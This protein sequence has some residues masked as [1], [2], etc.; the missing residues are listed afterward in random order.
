M[1]KKEETEVSKTQRLDECRVL[2]TTGVKGGVGKTITAFLM[3][4]LHSRMLEHNVLLINCDARIGSIATAYRAAKDP[5]VQVVDVPLV[6]DRSYETILKAIERSRL[7]SDGTELDEAVMPYVIVDMPGQH[8]GSQH[9][10]FVDV[11]LDENEAALLWL[12]DADVSCI[13]AMEAAR[14]GGMKPPVPCIPG[15]DKESMYRWMVS[16]VR[17]DYGFTEENELWIPQIP[18]NIL[19][20]IKEDLLTPRSIIEKTAS[21]VT[22]LS[23]RGMQNY[24]V[25]FRDLVAGVRIKR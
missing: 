7:G 3:T 22:S 16:K 12:V 9:M 21:G 25:R 24:M 11:L 5:R 8:E 15:M 20:F 18:L 4:D 1:E 14:E 2:V 17:A 10:E 23:A 19:P 6:D 13:D